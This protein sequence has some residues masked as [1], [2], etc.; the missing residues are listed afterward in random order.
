MGGT[1]SK[2]GFW[3]SI[4]GILSGVAAILTA[5]GAIGGFVSTHHSPQA[6][7]TQ[8]AAIQPAD[9]QPADTQPADTQP[10]DT[11]PAATQPAATQTWGDQANAICA[12][13]VKNG[14]GFVPS[15]GLNSQLPAAA[16][17]ADNWQ[18]VDDQLRKLPASGQ[19]QGTVSSMLQYWDQAI[20]ELRAAI[21]DAQN[22]DTSTEQQDLSTSN[23]LNTEGNSLANELGAGTCASGTF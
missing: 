10:A 23:T 11:Q 6:A 22:G 21:Q 19:Y 12:I 17:M 9:T 13:A 15:D 18:S 8:P 1:Q 7:D 16:Q 2:G 4:P 5:G 14:S 3:T 20:M